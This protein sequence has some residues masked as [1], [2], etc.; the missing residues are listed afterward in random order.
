M[1]YVNIKL[2][3]FFCITNFL[4]LTLSRFNSQLSSGRWGKK[5]NEKTK[6]RQTVWL[7]GRTSASPGI[8]LI[9]I[10]RSA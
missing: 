9:K 7:K 1:F 6:Y 8:L 2:T 3:N 10:W 4:I 5:M